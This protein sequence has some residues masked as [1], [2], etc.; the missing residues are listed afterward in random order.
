VSTTL[1]TATGDLA[2]PRVIVTDPAQVA[3]QTILDGLALWQGEWFLDQNAGFVWLVVLGQK[4][5][6]SGQLVSMLRAFL[7]SV[8][9]VTSVNATATFD[10]GKRHFSYQY[11]V[12]LNT[13]QQIKGGSGTPAYIVGAG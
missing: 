6:N 8:A 2:L 10:R 4:V 3:R 7:W 11:T 9:G 13:G 1:R 5:T 12:G